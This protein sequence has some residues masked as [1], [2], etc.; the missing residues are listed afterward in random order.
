MDTEATRS[1]NK[2]EE[3]RVL[4]ADLILELDR[5][6]QLALVLCGLFYTLIR[7]FNLC[8]V[9]N[10]VV[11]LY[12]RNRLVIVKFKCWRNFTGTVL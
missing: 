2:Q 5:K 9:Q 1:A 8:K 6:L 4:S 7:S 3:T 11:R 12:G 10:K